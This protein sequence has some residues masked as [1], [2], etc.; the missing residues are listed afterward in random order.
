MEKLKHSYYNLNFII[1]YIY[2]NG[3]IYHII[4]LFNNGQFEKHEI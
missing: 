4:P 2:N 1:P 3:M